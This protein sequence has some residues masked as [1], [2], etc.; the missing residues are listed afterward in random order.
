MV[1]CCAGFLYQSASF[2]AVY[3]KYPTVVDI[4][5]NMP[6]KIPLPAVT[7]C[8]I[9]LISVSKFCGAE[10]D[11]K[12]HVIDTK[13]YSKRYPAGKDLLKTIFKSRMPYSNVTKLFNVP[14]VEILKYTLANLRI[15]FLRSISLI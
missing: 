13:K 2:L 15:T 3:L 12:C 8:N 11:N 5:V 1:I 4:Q 6:V 7:F 9:N 14:Q 10:F